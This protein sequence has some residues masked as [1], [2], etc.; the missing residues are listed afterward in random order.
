MF[1]FLNSVN[2]AVESRLVAPPVWTPAAVLLTIGTV[3]TTNCSQSAHATLANAPSG[4]PRIGLGYVF[5]SEL[6]NI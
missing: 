3:T 6:Q 5:Y 4:K 2:V 1:C